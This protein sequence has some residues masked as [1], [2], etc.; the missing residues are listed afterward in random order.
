MSK[1]TTIPVAR[2]SFYQVTGRILETNE[3]FRNLIG[4]KQERQ[5]PALKISAF[6]PPEYLQDLYRI[7]E[8][9]GSR[10]LGLG[11]PVITG[12]GTTV[13]MELIFAP[14]YDLEG[15]KIYRCEMI[16]QPRRGKAGT[17]RKKAERP[18][19]EI[20]ADLLKKAMVNGELEIDI[21]P[22][23]SLLTGAGMGGEIL[24]RWKNDGREL[25][26]GEFLPQL[27]KAEI[28]NELDYY[29][30][31][32]VLQKMSEW[33][34]AGYKLLPFSVNLSNQHFSSSGF[35]ERMLSLTEAYGISKSLIGFEI[36]E[37]DIMSGREDV[38]TQ[39]QELRENGFRVSVDG[40]SGKYGAYGLIE[41]K[42]V[43][44]VKL[45]HSFTGV[46]LQSGFGRT[47]FKH[48]L[49]LAKACKVDAVCMGVETEAQ[50]QAV[51]EC[52]GRTA[53]GYLFARPMP[54]DEFFIRY[55]KKD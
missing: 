53:Q 26:P 19:G 23:Y 16:C 36:R 43:D 50:H 12:G 49:S 44:A 18:E 27:E 30:Y 3:E 48:L 40:F 7:L 8:T 1:V 45:D 5:E 54:L 10:A 24:I 28:I 25:M 17:G 31:V 22:Q 34:E 11:C 35:V 6:I 46:L 29:V 41:Q 51:V 14:S 20:Q 2:F 4:F 21:Q 52:G 39:I 37:D 42:L 13:P 33:Q 55:I 9:A 47:M 15:A 32:E 38:M